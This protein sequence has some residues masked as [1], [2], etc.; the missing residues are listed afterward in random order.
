MNLSPYSLGVQK[1]RCNMAGIKLSLVDDDYVVRAKTDLDYSGPN[2][3][4][5][6]FFKE[7]NEELI[8]GKSAYLEIEG[9]LLTR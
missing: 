4:V 8:T 1:R 7:M 5:E 6:A 3:R 9:R 2:N